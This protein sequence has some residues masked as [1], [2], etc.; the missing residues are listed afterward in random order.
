[1]KVFRTLYVLLLVSYIGVAQKKMD[2]AIDRLNDG[3]VPYIQ[4][5]EAIALEQVLFLDTRK[6]EEFQVSRIENAHWIGYDAYSSEKV[7]QLA[8]KLETPIVV[9][10][11]IGVRSE[12]IGEKLLKLG[13]TNVKNLYGGIF[14]W[15]NQGH[16]V[17]DG[18]GQRTEKVHAFDKYWGKLL[19]NGEKVYR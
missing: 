14:K 12:D 4:V 18:Q 3:S 1:M 8:P 11:S 9:Y 19:T 13:Y 17:F 5:E 16:P 15:K 10:C 2:K 6:R 7:R